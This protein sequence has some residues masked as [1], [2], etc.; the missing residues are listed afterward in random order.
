MLINANVSLTKT[1]WTVDIKF[2]YFL[3]LSKN[4]CFSGYPLNA[5]PYVAGIIKY[6]GCLTMS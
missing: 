6:T 3:N 1:F 5:T 4:V 2:L